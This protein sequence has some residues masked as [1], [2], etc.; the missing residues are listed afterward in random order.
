MS[1]NVVTAICAGL[2]EKG[3]A[4]FR[5]NFRGVGRSQGSYGHGKEE[6][7]DATAALEFVAVNTRVEPARLGILGYSF[8]A[9]VAFAVAVADM[10][11]GALALISPWLKDDEWSQ[12]REWPEPSF[13]IWG[14]HDEFV[15]RDMRKVADRLGSSSSYEV[16]PS[17]DHFWWGQEGRLAESVSAFFSGIFTG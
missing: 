2:M 14:G 13:L 9:N 11:V 17:T 5:F 3:I 4:A 15:P 12:L 8:G 10:R 16:V 1:N 7:R 6:Q